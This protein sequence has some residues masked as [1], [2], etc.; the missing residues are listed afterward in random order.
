VLWARFIPLIHENM[1]NSYRVWAAFTAK[2]GITS[3]SS[4]IRSSAGI[5]LAAGPELLPM[6]NISHYRFNILLT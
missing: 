4:R 2:L 6:V 5:K 3:L 1:A